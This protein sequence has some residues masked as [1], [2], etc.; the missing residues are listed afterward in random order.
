MPPNLN[1]DEFELQ[2]SNMV[3]LKM[4]F[5]LS[6]LSLVI[7]VGRFTFYCRQFMSEYCEKSA[8]GSLIMFTLLSFTSVAALVLA[9]LG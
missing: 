5:G 4:N 9:S 1:L 8:V 2:S 3:G 7:A 6:T